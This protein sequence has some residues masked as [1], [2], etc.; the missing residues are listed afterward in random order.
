LLGSPGLLETIPAVQADPL[1][2]RTKI[3]QGAVQRELDELSNR[4][5]ERHPRVLDA[6]SELASLNG[7]LEGHINRVAGTIAKDY[8]LAQQRVASINSNASAT[9]PVYRCHLSSPKSS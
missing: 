9:L 3:E 7:A 1:V 8:Q 2:Q 5:G 6:K 4:Y